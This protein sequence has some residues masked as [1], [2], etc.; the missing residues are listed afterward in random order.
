[1]A[2]NTG[3]WKNIIGTDQKI[4][5]KFCWEK[6]S[7]INIYIDKNGLDKCMLVNIYWINESVE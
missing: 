5:T 1:M 2:L 3:K 7:S 4:T 6:Y